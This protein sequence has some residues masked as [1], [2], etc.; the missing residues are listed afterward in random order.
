MKT[1]KDW[2]TMYVEELRTRAHDPLFGGSAEARA[3]AAIAEELETRRRAFFNATPTIAEAAAESGY[4]PE[5]LRKLKS[6][7]KWSGQRIDMPRRP[8]R[9]APEAQGLTLAGQVLTRARRTGT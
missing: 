2:L 1:V 7:G 6:E 4:S 3:A 5:Q 9:L 8:G